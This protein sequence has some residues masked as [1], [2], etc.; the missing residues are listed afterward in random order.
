MVYKY[1]QMKW[2]MEESLEAFYT[3]WWRRQATIKTPTQEKVET[4][5]RRFS[6]RL[7]TTTSRRRRRNAAPTQ[8]DATVTS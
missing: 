5:T 1:I 7:D 8:Q 4:K 2:K 3:L 6:N